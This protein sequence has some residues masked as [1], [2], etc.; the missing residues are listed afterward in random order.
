MVWKDLFQ[1]WLFELGTFPM[2]NAQ[3]HIQISDD[4]NI[5][6][7]NGI[8][9]P[10]VNA[11]NNLSSVIALRNNTKSDLVSGFSNVGTVKSEPYSYDVNEF[12]GTIAEQN[13]A[14]IFLGSFISITTVISKTGNSANVMFRSDNVTGWE[15]GTRFIKAQGGNVGI[16]PNKARGTGLN[17]G[18]NVAETFQ[19]AEILSW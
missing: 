18:G 19:W 14:K 7:G 16:I 8:N 9:N 6:T 1:A 11:F 10:S 2:V 4:A 15:S 5:I 3:P 13:V 17:L 12:Y